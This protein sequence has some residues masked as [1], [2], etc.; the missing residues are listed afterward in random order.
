MSTIKE[1]NILGAVALD[2]LLG[3]LPVKIE[4]NILR[5]ALR[6][7]A[8]VML[9]EVKQ[10]IPVAS[11]DLRDSVRITTRVRRGVVSASVKAGNAKA[12]YAGMVEF[13]TRPHLIKVDDKDRGVNRRTGKLASVTTV[14]RRLAIGGTVIGPSVAHPGAKARPYMRPA[15]DAGFEA[16]VGA[17]QKHVRDRLT[18]QGLEVPEAVPAGEE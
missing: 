18:K 1:Q 10:R 11:G 9:A 3:T 5:G 4:K 16:A 15:A 8:K 13:G 7:G 6:A 2:A 12:Y 14:N 17:V